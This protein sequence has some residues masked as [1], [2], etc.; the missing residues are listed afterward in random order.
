MN[1]LR[2]KNAGIYNTLYLGCKGIWRT[3]KLRT[4]TYNF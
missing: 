1:I 2:S 3:G 4:E